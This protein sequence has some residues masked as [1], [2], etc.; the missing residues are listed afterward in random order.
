MNG[1]REIRAVDAV[2]ELQQVE[3][4]SPERA[5]HY[6]E[7]AAGYARGGERFVAVASHDP[8]L[9]TEDLYIPA[10]EFTSA[11]RE[12]AE[13][14]LAAGEA[15]RVLL[16]VEAGSS[17]TPGEPF[18]RL[19][20]YLVRTGRPSDTKPP[21]DVRIVPVDERSTGFVKTLMRQAMLDGYHGAVGDPTA[22]DSYLDRTVRFG[23]PDGLHG[24]VA[25]VAGRAIG[26]ITWTRP[27]PDDV[28]GRPFHDLVDVHVLPEFEKRTLTAALTRAMLDLLAGSGAGM[29]GNVIEG[30]GGEGDR[31]H[32][33]LLRTG[34]TPLFALWVAQS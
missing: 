26:H 30:A 27:E 15:D 13:D 3:P 20:R 31:L 16:R 17:L 11:G 4:L 32:A 22:I 33:G 7:L 34:W 6:A 14:L 19:V 23:G 2:E 24:L 29:R 18:R 25:E 12:L 1:L 9:D 28:T 10:H 5:R 8:V 21:Q